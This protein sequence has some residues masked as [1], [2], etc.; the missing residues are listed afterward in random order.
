MLERPTGEVKLRR[1][2]SGR[3]LCYTPEATSYASGYSEHCGSKTCWPCGVVEKKDYSKLHKAK[4]KIFQYVNNS[5]FWQTWTIRKLLVQWMTQSP[6]NL[7]HI[8]DRD[9]KG[10]RGVSFVKVDIFTFDGWKGGRMC[11]Y[12]G[13]GAIVR[14]LGLVKYSGREQRRGAMRQS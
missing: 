3:I 8:A 9:F 11:S 13:G 12:L 7:L 1:S 5:L 6:H 2:L 4:Q 10:R 14:L